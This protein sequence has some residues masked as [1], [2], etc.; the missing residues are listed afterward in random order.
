MLA[1]TILG[2]LF[3]AVT[4]SLRSKWQAEQSRRV[5]QEITVIWMKTHSRA[6]RE[7]EEWI[8]TLD[9]TNST[10]SAS[11]AFVAKESAGGPSEPIFLQLNKNVRVTPE[12]RADIKPVHF[13]PDGRATQTSLLVTG[14][15]GASWRVHTDWTGQPSMERVTTTTRTRMF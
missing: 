4:V 6:W 7:G 9:E 13:F 11:T 10:L 14:P 12:G 8:V 5:A 3:I 15:D 1:I 2:L